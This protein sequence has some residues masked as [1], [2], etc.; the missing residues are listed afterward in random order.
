MPEGV[1]IA[2]GPVVAPVGTVR[3]SEVAVFA[4][5]VA[6]VPLTLARVAP[7]RFDP[8]TVTLCPIDAAI[9]EKPAMLTPDGGAMS[10]RRL[11]PL[12]LPQRPPG[13]KNAAVRLREKL[14]A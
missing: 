14:L 1:V 5:M 7:D 2:I 9:G 12:K 13:A 4:V 10:R 6:V 11:M 3:G 8:D